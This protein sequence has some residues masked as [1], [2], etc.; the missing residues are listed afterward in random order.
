MQ[1]FL[2]AFQSKDE[3]AAWSVL[4]RSRSRDR[5][6][7]VQSLLDEYLKLSDSGHA[8]QA[9]VTLQRI[10]FAGKLEQDRTADR[11]ASDVAQFYSEANPAARQG[12]AQARAQ[13]KTAR[14][15]YRLNRMAEAAEIYQQAKES[16]ARLG[17]DAEAL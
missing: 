12:L 8:D 16:F 4:S 15:L 11:F 14:D 9:A 3:V 6:A 17:D 5:N 2:S 1:D 7:I 13:L 10:L